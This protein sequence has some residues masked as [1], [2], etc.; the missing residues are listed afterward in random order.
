MTRD[1]VYF[2]NPV[3]LISE[4]L[5]ADIELIRIARRDL[6]DISPDPQGSAQLVLIIAAVLQI[7]ELAQQGIAIIGLSDPDREEHI[8]VLLRIRCCIDA[9]NRCHDDRISALEQ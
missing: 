6:N 8:L 7:D 3:N 2:G 5:D 9:G 1:R 4:H